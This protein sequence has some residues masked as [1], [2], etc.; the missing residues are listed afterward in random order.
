MAWKKIT[1]LRVILFLWLG[2]LLQRINID[3]FTLE[4]LR[5]CDVIYPLLWSHYDL[6]IRTM[7]NSVKVKI[8]KIDCQKN[9]ITNY[10]FSI[11]YTVRLYV[12]TFRFKPPN[13]NIVSL[14]YTQNTFWHNNVRQNF[15]RSKK[16]WNVALRQTDYQNYHYCIFIY[17][18]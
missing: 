11:V 12:P 9:Q 17:I 13:S 4:V 15:L 2:D 8:Y 1:H 16:L 3:F 6:H 10:E 14:Q 7:Q 18:K 5:Q